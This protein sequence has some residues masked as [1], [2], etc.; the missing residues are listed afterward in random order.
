MV[1][2]TIYGQFNNL[3]TSVDYSNTW[4]APADGQN[5]DLTF[6]NSVPGGSYPDGLG[7]ANLTVA[8]PEPSTYAA[9]LGALTLGF[10]GVRRFRRR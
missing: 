7:I 4:F 10:V 5:A 3:L 2:G 6:L 8:V 9:I 1:A